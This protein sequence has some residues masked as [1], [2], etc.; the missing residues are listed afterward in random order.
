MPAWAKRVYLE[1]LERLKAEYMLLHAQAAA[2]PYMKPSDARAFM[3][4]LTAYARPSFSSPAART[5]EEVIASATAL[6]FGVK[7][8]GPDGELIDAQ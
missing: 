5:S 1:E 8:E 4:R 7:I 3:R 6:G 2:L